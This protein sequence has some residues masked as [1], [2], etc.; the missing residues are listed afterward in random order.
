MR[1][2]SWS[3][4][5]RRFH[6]RSLPVVTA[7]SL[8]QRAGLSAHRIAGVIGE[9]EAGMPVYSKRRCHASLNCVDLLMRFR[10]VLTAGLKV[11]GRLS[12]RRR[13]LLLGISCLSVVSG[14]AFFWAF[15]L[16][17]SW[18]VDYDRAGYARIIK[19]FGAD[20]Q[21]HCG[22]RL[23]DVGPELGIEDVPWDDGNVQNLPGSYR[24]YHFRGF[25]LYVTLDYMR[26][27]LTQDM[28]LG[29]GSSTERSRGRDLLW[30]HP[31][32]PPFVIIDGISSRAERMKRYWSQV[33]EN[34]REINEEMQ[35]KRHRGL[36]RQD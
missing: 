34:I 6:V 32:N 24:I 29:R 17:S 22:R 25:A 12:P 8:W 10:S 21:H 5:P 11:E 15:G 35:L 30:I 14:V 33:D 20:S 7:Q 28:L 31:R 23:Y 16:L 19:V 9:V 27:G 2:H 1:S 18:T 4:V 13:N 26:E 3:W 36:N